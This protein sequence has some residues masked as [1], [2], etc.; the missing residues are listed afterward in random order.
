MIYSKT[1]EYAIRALVYF[2]RN[3]AKPAKIHRVSRSSGVPNA[4]VSKIFQCLVRSGVLA[5]ERGPR[6]GYTLL[7]PPSRL[8][9]MQVIQALDDLSRSPFS[10]CIMGLHQCSNHNPCPL[11]ETWAAAKEEML[12]KLNLY[13][14]ADIAGLLGRF[15]RG[16]AS[17]LALSKKMRGV[18]SFKR[19]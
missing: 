17:R 3:S 18:F 13:T 8:S 15:R 2:N 12:S 14:I 19:G 16:R 11:H 1:C 9:L 10:N 4:Y 7:I 6:G 5:S